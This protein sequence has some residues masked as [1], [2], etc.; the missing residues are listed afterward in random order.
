M[1]MWGIRS[2]FYRSRP[3][4]STQPN[5][6][7]ENEMIAH[8]LVY[9]IQRMWVVTS[10]RFPA[11]SQLSANHHNNSNKWTINKDDLSPRSSGICNTAAERTPV[12][13]CR[14]HPEIIL[15]RQPDWLR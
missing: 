2:S 13:L 8:V 3:V 5:D 9:T 12:G 7:K 11:G 15:E 1:E 6:N 14:R 4:K 10:N